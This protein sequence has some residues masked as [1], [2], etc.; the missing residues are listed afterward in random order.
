MPSLTKRHEEEWAHFF[1][2]KWTCICWPQREPVWGQ[3]WH[4]GIGR[5]RRW[6]GHGPFFFFFFFLSH[7]HGIWKF[8]GQGLNPS[9]SYSVFYCCSNAVSLTYCTTVGTPLKKLFLGGQASATPMPQ[10]PPQPLQRQ[11]RILNR[12]CCRRTPPGPKLLME[13]PNSGLPH[14]VIYYPFYETIWCRIFVECR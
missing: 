6:R 12:L 7:T 13:L 14:Q 8:L 9:H 1:L 3:C 2:Q 5:G 10:Q 4:I 11:C